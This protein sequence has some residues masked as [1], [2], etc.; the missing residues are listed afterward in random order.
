MRVIVYTST[1]LGRAIE[2]KDREDFL[3]QLSQIAEEIRAAIDY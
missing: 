1:G 2:A 3:E